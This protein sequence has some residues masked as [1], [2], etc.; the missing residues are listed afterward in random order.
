M[1]KVELYINDSLCDLS[2]EETIEVDYTNFDI[3]KIDSRGGARSYSFNIP[4]T[5]RNKVV[6][7][8]PEMVNN[9]SEVPYLR[10]PCL[11]LVDGVDVQIRFAEVES[12]GDSY[13]IRVYGSNSDLFSTLSDKKLFD[14]D[15]S[16][17]DHIWNMTNVVDSRL[18]TEGYIYALIDFHE[19]S[20]N[21]ACNNDANNFRVD[22]CPPSFFVNTILENIFTHFGYTLENEIE[23]DTA[24]L[25]MPLHFTAVEPTPF[26]NEKY[27]GVLGI[28]SQMEVPSVQ[29]VVKYFAFDNV[30]SYTGSYYSF[31]Y[32]VPNSNRRA[33][34]TE[35]SMFFKMTFSLD[36]TVT[37]A[38][39]NIVLDFQIFDANG[40]A[41]STIGNYTVTPNL[42]VGTHNI[43]FVF[44]IVSLAVPNG[45]L[46]YTVGFQNNAWIFGN[47]DSYFVESTSTITIS[48]VVYMGNLL[49]YGQLLNMSALM[50][51]MTI[52]DFVKNYL[53]LFGLIPIVNEATN[54]I[55][56]KKFNSIVGNLGNAYDW[57]GKLDYTNEPEIRYLMNE[58]AQNN[59]FK[60]KQD[61]E[62][63]IPTD[64]NSQ[65]V[66]SNKNLELE[67]N[68]V[69]LDF[70][71]TNS[72]FRLNTLGVGNR[73]LPQIGVYKQGDWSNDKMPR[74]LQLTKKSAADWG[75]DPIL[76][77]QYDDYS[78]STG[79]VDNIPV[80]HFIDIAE[81]FNL[82]FGN[83]ILQ[84]YY[85]QI[86]EILSRLKIVKVEL[87]LNASDISQLDFTRPVFIQKF[88]SYFYISSVKGF[89]YTENKS[90][91]VE[92][93]KL[94]ING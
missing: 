79:V 54:T 19:D 87:R 93:V 49:Q 37:N 5:N 68:L 30:S 92:L 71:S 64:A 16:E 31:P 60:W 47:T 36:I 32:Y 39:N 38:I 23:S 11:V 75:L 7:E 82:G 66:I 48:D 51:D 80:C 53:L 50:P 22:Y 34:R 46:Y 88:E 86:S 83:N 78:T 29:A 44:N 52:L 70:A 6:L 76:G 69:E 18:N 58:Y 24:N 33:L 94:N 67:K 17:F 45:A 1:A 61:G 40:N 85:T 89:S 14:L 8:N 62:E 84:N 25:I 59:Y 90:T 73:I 72:N 77:M 12:A 2:G 26:I 9:L 55:Y 91:L 42:T 65:I 10:L 27:D 15:F 63:P 28:G 3:S 4:K 74:L 57:S 21:F 81:P 35:D 56:L 20:P 41:Y 13:G 43:S